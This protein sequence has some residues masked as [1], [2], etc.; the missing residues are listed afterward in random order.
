MIKEVN[1]TV[2]SLK[3]MG[4]LFLP[5]GIDPPYPGVILCH[6]VP[7]GTVDPTD[8]G[9][10]L[11]AKTISE[12]GFAAYTFRFRGTG[13]SEGNFDIVGWTHD[14]EAVI[15]YLW[16][17]PEIDTNRLALVGFSA[18]A[19]VSIYIGAQDKRI[20]AVVTCASPAD[21]TAISD[22]RHAQL[23]VNYFRKIGIIRD[24]DFPPSFQT[25]LNNFR[26][27][28][29]LHSVADISPRPLLLV[30]SR[31]DGVVPV[32]S[33]EKLYARAGEPKQIIILEGSE[34]RLRRNEKAVEAIIS[35][36]KKQMS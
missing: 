31:A 23:T 36:L 20:S 26:K 33:S 32:S 21:F 9:Y 27:V 17:L 18:G 29:A 1:L 2:D 11:L 34:H 13:S 30:H 25:W 12:K 19:A 28:D 16:E 3:I 15:D 7:S 6:G 14:L 35:W 5:E 8:G 4:Q 22:A 24:P 10:P